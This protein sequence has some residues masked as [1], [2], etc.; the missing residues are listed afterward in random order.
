MNT[1]LDRE[2]EEC[3]RGEFAAAFLDDRLKVLPEHVHD[4]VDEP[5]LL[6]VELDLRE[7]GFLPQLH[8]HLDLALKQP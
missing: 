6:T 1:Y 8:E 7:A 3:G 4:A 5:S 2:F